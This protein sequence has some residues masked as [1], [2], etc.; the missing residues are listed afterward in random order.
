[1]GS[2]QPT[3]LKEIEKKLSEITK[4]F[5]QKIKLILHAGTPKTDTTSIQFFLNENRET[6]LGYGI[7]YAQNDGLSIEP[8][9]QWIVGLLQKNNFT[10]FLDKFEKVISSANE[11]TH[12]IILSTEGIYNHWWDCSPETKYFLSMLSSHFDVNLWVYFRDPVSFSESLY[13]QYL[14]NPQMASIECYGKDLSLD[15]MMEDEWFKNHLDYVGFLMECEQLFD[16]EHVFTFLLKAN[17]IK[18]VCNSL[19]V[20]I[21]LFN[22]SKTKR[23]KKLSC[24]LIDT[25]RLFNRHEIPPK[26]KQILVD[27]LYE[28]EEKVGDFFETKEICNGT[29]EKII[30]LVSLQHGY[31]NEKYHLNF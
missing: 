7:L 19:K 20:D 26:K 10:S 27:S 2:F 11:E 15:E 8:K 14:K 23:N 5:P 31:L 6:L 21:T 28:L 12:T 4:R 22:T 9:H 17:I 25:L 24:V 13:R 18:Q 1:L 30:N 16:K 29:K 3:N